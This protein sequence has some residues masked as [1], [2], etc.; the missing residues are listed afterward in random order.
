MEVMCHYKEMY[1]NENDN[2]IKYNELLYLLVEDI[3]DLVPDTTDEAFW[4]I[5]EIV[6][7]QQ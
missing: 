7:C 6:R 3:G 2:K 1:G 4:G 5:L